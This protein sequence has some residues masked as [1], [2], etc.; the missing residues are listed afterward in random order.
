MGAQST[1]RKVKHVRLA[2]G[3]DERVNIRT[4]ISTENHRELYARLVKD[5]PRMHGT[6]GPRKPRKSK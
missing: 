6:P 4:G 5:G 2:Y 1:S 3:G